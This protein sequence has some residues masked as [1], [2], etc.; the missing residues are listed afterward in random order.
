M[1]VMDGYQFVKE[2]EKAFGEY[3]TRCC[4]LI[5]SSTLDKSEMAIFKN[6]PLVGDFIQKPLQPQEI[7]AYLQDQQRL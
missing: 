7:F 6:H 5:C 2:Y 4:I 1:P 3:A